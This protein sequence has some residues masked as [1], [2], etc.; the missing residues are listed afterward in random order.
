MTQLEKDR[1]EADIQCW[2][3]SFNQIESLLMQGKTVAEIE[4]GI[5]VPVLVKSIMLSIS[6]H[7]RDS[8]REA[9]AQALELA[10]SVLRKSELPIRECAE[11]SLQ[12]ED[13]ISEVLQVLSSEDKDQASTSEWVGY[14]L[15]ALEIIQAWMDQGRYYWT[16]ITKKKVF[17]AVD[18]SSTHYRRTRSMAFGSMH[19]VG[20]VAGMLKRKDPRLQIDV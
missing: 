3:L 15:K 14:Y 4:A 5:K 16:E 9:V 11:Q 10:A 18:R 6:W 13:K 7:C 19:I 20:R 17:T 12:G 1:I 8:D 2:A